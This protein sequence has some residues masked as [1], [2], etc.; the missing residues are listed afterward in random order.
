GGRGRGIGFARYKNLGCYVA[1]IVEIEAQ[2]EVRVK[3]AWAAIDA[4]QAINPDGIVN[5]TE[6]G[7]IQTVSWTLKEQI[8]FDRERILTRTWE[9][10]PI[11]TFPEAPEVEVTVI[12]RPEQPP[13]GAGEGAQGPTGAAIANAVDNALGVRLR[14]MPLTRDKLITA[15]AR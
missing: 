3:R 11:L 15:L 7:L 14:D 10:Y 4:G 9:D 1:V 5:Q 13:L 6:G 2:E 8:N 12:D